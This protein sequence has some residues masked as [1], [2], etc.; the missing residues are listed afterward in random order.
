MRS[1]TNHN[2]VVAMKG[3]WARIGSVVVGGGGG[4]V[5]VKS[6]DCCNL[7]FLVLSQLEEIVFTMALLL[8]STMIQLAKLLL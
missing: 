6:N 7:L 3:I 8:V 2:F 4:G 5:L 1:P